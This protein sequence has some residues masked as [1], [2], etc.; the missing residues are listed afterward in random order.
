MTMGILLILYV[1]AVLLNILFSKS[2]T[3]S[4]DKF[5]MLLPKKQFLIMGSICCLIFGICIH[6][7]ISSGQTGIGTVLFFILFLFGILLIIAPVKG[8]WGTSVDGDELISKR[9]WKR[10]NSIRIS[11]IDRIVLIKGGIKV[12]VRNNQEAVIKIESIDTNINNFLSRIRRDNIRVEAKAGVNPKMMN[13]STIPQNININP[14]QP[15]NP[16]NNQQNNN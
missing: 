4:L 10:K 5:D 15:M 13:Q 9:F 2:A 11:D 6:G 3:T 7:S 12:Y 1:V 14:Q 16:D 8:F